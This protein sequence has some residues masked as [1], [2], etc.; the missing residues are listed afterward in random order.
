[1]PSLSAKTPSSIAQVAII[2]EGETGNVGD[3]V[4]DVVLTHG[5]G[6]RV[7]VDIVNRI[8][9]NVRVLDGGKNYTA[10]EA[11]SSN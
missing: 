8:T 2:T 11:V 9:K 1:M 5:K 4:N 3:N 10:N 6:S 7:L